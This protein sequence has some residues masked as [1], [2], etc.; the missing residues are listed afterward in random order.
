MYASWIEEKIVYMNNFVTYLYTGRT[1]RNYANVFRVR[2]KKKLHICGK[3]HI[4]EIVLF[5]IVIDY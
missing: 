5:M 1:D 2:K 3:S 4:R